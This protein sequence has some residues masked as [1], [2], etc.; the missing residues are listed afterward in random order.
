MFKFLDHKPEM[1]ILQRT[2]DKA[3]GPLGWFLCS[4]A[5]VLL[6]SAQGF[7]MAFGLDLAAYRSIY[8]SIFSLLRMAVGDF[9]YDELESSQHL[10]GP[11]M[12]FLFI[13]LVFFVLMSMFIALISEAY[14]AA[15]DERTHMPAPRMKRRGYG[16]LW[17]VTREADKRVDMANHL[18]L[19]S[20]ELYR[21]LSP[22]V[23]ALSS[24]KHRADVLEEVAKLQ[25][26]RALPTSGTHAGLFGG[27]PDVFEHKRVQIAQKIVPPGSKL[28]TWVKTKRHGAMRWEVDQFKARANRAHGTRFRAL[29]NIHGSGP[30]ELSFRR[31]DIIIVTNRPEHGRWRGFRHEDGPV[32]SGEFDPIFVYELKNRLD[33]LGHLDASSSDEDRLHS[34][35]SDDEHDG[36]KVHNTRIRQGRNVD[37]TFDDPMELEHNSKGEGPLS[38][39]DRAPTGYARALNYTADIKTSAEASVITRKLGRE[40]DPT[41]ASPAKK[42]SA[43]MLEMETCAVAERR[44][45]PSASTPQEATS[46]TMHEADQLVVPSKSHGSEN[47]VADDNANTPSTGFGSVTNE[48]LQVDAVKQKLSALALSVVP[49]L[50]EILQLNRAQQIE[51]QQ[52]TRAQLALAEEVQQLRHELRVL[53]AAFDRRVPEPPKPGEGWRR[54]THEGFRSP[55]FPHGREYWQHD[56]GTT[57]WERPPGVPTAV[58]EMQNR[59]LLTASASETRATNLPG[60]VSVDSSVTS[61]RSIA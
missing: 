10:L 35:C 55:E 36:E 9:D 4:F 32:V 31:N 50:Q 59:K 38:P 48:S 12:F 6:G 52:A 19:I 46:L 21:E 34:D 42:R 20:K 14:D 1:S 57:S 60:E 37:G 47:Y 26:S 53:S 22:F 40:A 11:A 18:G 8:T 5:I 2:L 43:V 13:V 15:R 39:H 30:N 49:D 29:A 54:M 56:D 51:A 7:Y 28:G 45:I 58:Q 44:Y 16:N 24:F 25:K 23:G 61:N 27:L 17:N 33:G 41:R 3:A